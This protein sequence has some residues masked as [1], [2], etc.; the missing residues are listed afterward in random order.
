MVAKLQNLMSLCDALGVCKFAVLTGMRPLLLV[1]WLNSITGWNFDLDGFM[2]TGERL[3]N[4][5]RLFNVRL[6][7]RR[8]DDTLPV[9]LLLQPRGTGGAAKELP[10]LD[11][12]LRDYYEYRGWNEEG[13]PTH[14]KLSELGLTDF[15]VT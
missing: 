15:E 4:L 3:Y 6:G 10:D 7:I 1:D 9:R 13:I 2:K 5:K 11:T 12:M 8:K 14:E